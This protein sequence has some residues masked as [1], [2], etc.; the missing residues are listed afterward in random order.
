MKTQPMRVPTTSNLTELLSAA[1]RMFLQKEG[2]GGQTALATRLGVTKSHL[3]NLLAGRTAWPDH[4]KE[5]V[6]RIYQCSVANLLTLGEEYLATGVWFPYGQSILHLPPQSL[7][8]LEALF[9]FAAGNHGLGIADTLFTKKTLVIM[10]PTLCADFIKG[11]LTDAE[12]YGSACELCQQICP[13]QS[14]IS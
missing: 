14:P 11:K 6:A 4:L 1:V 8:R 13:K 9:H 10:F 7:E 3:N 2:R 5:K 12:A